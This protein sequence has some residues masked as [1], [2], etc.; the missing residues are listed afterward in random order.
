[1]KIVRY[2]RNIKLPKKSRYIALGVFDGV[3][4]GHRKLI[5]LTV[6]KAKKNKGISIV[7]TFDPHPD[8]IIIPE[9][10][11]FLL[12][13]LKERINLIR[14]LEVDIF[15]IIK[16]SKILSKMSPKDFIVKILVNSLQV[17]ELFVGFNYKFGF[18][19]KGN[20]DCLK[21][22]GKIYKFKTSIL[23]PE[24]INKTII[25]STIIKEYI[26]LGDTKKAKKLLGHNVIISGRVI[27]G[28]GRGKKLL[29]FA[30]ANIEIPLEK[31]LPANG[32]Y[33]VEINIDNQKYYGLMNIGI[34][35]TFKEKNKTVEVH[36]I[37]FNKSI[38][39]QVVNINILQKIRNE[40]YFNHPG[41]LK[42]QIEDD[43]L[44]AH[45]MIN[46]M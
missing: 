4:L 27:S 21:E 3:H 7:V 41:L 20:V 22:Y 23:K 44:T 37:N 16:F 8:R 33:L 24:V 28:K 39:N 38:Y 35:P 14:D 2:S 32:V 45:K 10:N 1:M 15:L 13:T 12:T 30:T 29:N 17:K 36:I 40:K 6:N 42:K 18:Q 31:I 46:N 9:N 11:V 25:S 43:I 19:G 26:R 5:K 34:K